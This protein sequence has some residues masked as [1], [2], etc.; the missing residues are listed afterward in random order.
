MKY[1][2]KILVI[3]SCLSLK[4]QEYKFGSALLDKIALIE[5]NGNP[6]A[7]GD[8]GLAIGLF[9]I[10]KLAYNDAISYINQTYNQHILKDFKC[11]KGYKQDCLN[12]DLSYAIADA[13]LNYL[14][15][16]FKKNNPKE[17]LTDLKLYMIWNMGYSGARV[18][19]F[20]PDHPALPSN[21]R[22]A[23]KRAKLY[24]K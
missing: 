11:F 8:N 17:K 2:S 5:S 7:V 19:S 1:L 24:L 22:R 3:F 10:H 15:S 14:V 13:Y 4:A 20:N 9:Q 18:Y 21:A 16:I 6:K 12:P 23:I